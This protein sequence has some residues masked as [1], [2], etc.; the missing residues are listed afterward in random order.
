MDASSVIA[1]VEKRLARLADDPPCRFVETT[2]EDADPASRPRAAPGV[3]CPDPLTLGAVVFLSRQGYSS[4]TSLR[5]GLQN[6]SSRY[7]EL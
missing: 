4:S 2:R 3:G 1:N 5:T 6:I 7:E